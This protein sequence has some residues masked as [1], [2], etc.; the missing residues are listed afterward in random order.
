MKYEGI[1]TYQHSEHRYGNN[2]KLISRWSVIYQGSVIGEGASEEKALS[3]ASTSMY[4]VITKS[5][6][7]KTP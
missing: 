3:N 7:K 6:K 5:S 4:K 1:E 2:P